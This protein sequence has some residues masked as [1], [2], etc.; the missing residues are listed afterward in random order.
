MKKI[1]LLVS[2]LLCIYG[3][4]AQVTLKISS[5]ANMV[6]SGAAKVVMDTGQFVNNGTYMDSTGV[7]L[8][9]GGITFS[10]AGT[11][12]FNNFIVN[13]TQH[14]LVNSLVSVYN[15]AT[16]TSGNLDANSNL[17]IRSDQNSIA[18]MVVTGVLTN[19]VSGIIAR[20]SIVT[21][22]CPSYSSALSLNISGTAMHY[23]WQSSVDSTTW[24]DIVGATTGAY[25][26]TVSATSFYRCN[27][28]TTNSAFSE[29]TPGIKL[30]LTGTI[31]TVA[32]I[33]GTTSVIAGSTTTLSDVTTGGVWSSANTAIATV[34]SGTG[35]VTGIAAGTALIS[36]TVT[37]SCGS[38]AAMMIVTVNP[39]VSA[40][41]GV[42]TVCAGSTTTLSDATTGGT[43]S[44]S[45]A[46]IATVGSAGVVTGVTAGTTLISYTV[47]GTSVTTIVTVNSSPSPIS[48]ST[49]LIAGNS[50]TLL[51][52]PAGGVWSSS[53]TSIAT[54]GS[55]TGIVSAIAAGTVTIS[56]TLGS[57]CYTSIIAT[58]YPVGT[59]FCSS[60]NNLGAPG[61]S[62]GTTGNTSIVIDGAGNKYVVY[63]DAAN[64][65]KIT[66]MENSGSGWYVVGTPAFS[67]G[68]IDYPSIAL[69]VTGVPYVVYRDAGNSFKAV[70]KK[71][72][73]GSWVSVGPSTGLSAGTANYTTIAFDGA[74]APYVAYTDVASSNKVTVMK[75][76]GSSW[77]SVGGTGFTSGGADNTVVAIDGSN[78]PYIIYSDNTVSNKATVM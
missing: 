40:I 11:S 43:W 55:S 71:F 75:F 22:A 52:A 41:A 25:S 30:T 24:S 4:G 26:A 31:P 77:S 12:R 34:G 39:P 68:Q 29:S 13:N 74:N 63:K 1:I 42:T 23:Q 14:S 66:V 51:D 72:N 10:G 73:A 5:G 2:W 49:T 57:G 28:T 65:Y 50:A 15:T 8:A 38:A 45:N 67:T 48:G 47:S 32:A 56:Y 69:D 18:N 33:S 16:L 54:V 37:N 27:L 59:T 76:N 35:I 70:V 17:S 19:N 6:T 46:A 3:A 20:A 58:V 64:G 60:W 21:G 61:F 7:F 9:S 53:N 78:A 62:A 44:S 36:Y